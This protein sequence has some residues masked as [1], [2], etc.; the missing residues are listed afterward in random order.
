MGPIELR[1][2]TF[3]AI[4]DAWQLEPTQQ[5]AVKH[6]CLRVWH[7]GRDLGGHNSGSCRGLS[8]HAMQAMCTQ[9]RV[10]HKCVVAVA[11]A[12]R[13]GRVDRG[14]A[15]STQ[16]TQRFQMQGLLT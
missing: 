2:F 15:R 1:G 8:L 13:F 16:Y 10:G 14:S 11:W 9:P 5:R 7:T 3:W 4:H 6:C 12:G